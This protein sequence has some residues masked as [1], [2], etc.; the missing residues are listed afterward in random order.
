MET[1]SYMKGSMKTLISFIIMHID[2][3]CDVIL[4]ASREIKK[5]VVI[6]NI[7]KISTALF[8]YCK[9]LKNGKFNIGE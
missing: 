9:K 8:S 1:C 7:I 2:S 6:S 4:I 5:A 3:N